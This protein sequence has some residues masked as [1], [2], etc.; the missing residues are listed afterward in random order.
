[1]YIIPISE[2]FE[3]DLG[4]NKLEKYVINGGKPLFGD[5]VIS[6]AKNVAVAM[7]PACLLSD[8]PCIIENVPF[9]RD[10]DLMIKILKELGAEVDFIDAS[11]LRIDSRKVTTTSC[12]AEYSSKMRASYY[13]LGALISK[14]GSAEI[15]LP[16]GCDLGPRP[17]DQHIK[18]FEALGASIQIKG[19]RVIA[20]AE[21]LT[22][23]SVF[24]DIVSVG[25]T[26]N[27]M[28]AAVK[29]KGLTV[30]ENAAKEPH[31]VDLANFLNSMG[32][33]I[34]GAGTD[35]IKIKGVDHLK[36][37]R[38]QII[39]DQIE[40]GTYM[41]MAAATKGDILIK[42]VI[43]KHMEP[44]TAKLEEMGI[45]IQELGDSIH[46]FYQ[47]TLKKAN[48][49]TLPYPGFPTDMQPLITTLLALAEGTSTVTES[50]WD[51][52]FKYVEELK[53]MGANITVNGSTAIIEG[54]RELTGAPV[55]ATD[56]RAGAAMLV[57]GVVAKGTTEIM[58]IYHIDRGYEKVI[59]KIAGVGGDIK[60]IVEE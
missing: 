11:T 46:V 6:G 37:S 24:L 4:V 21:H 32:A 1:M 53:K 35:I 44:I 50:I 26:I 3:L 40:A 57:A 55:Y 45:G 34:K 23:D 5:I 31:I 20:N 54:V 47:G 38:Y 27:I 18:G 39:P 8:E 48:V 52:R 51:S 13:L 56:L 60:R 33:N 59:E 36:G 17:M 22:G 30:I 12:S 58:D 19:G 7:I 49:K 29:A 42:N 43:P 16:G 2:I 41:I 28:L 10:V 25:A 15:S 9:I 14:Y